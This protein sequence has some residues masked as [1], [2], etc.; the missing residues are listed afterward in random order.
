M[1]RYVALVTLAA[2]VA[3]IVFGPSTTIGANAAGERPQVAAALS[4]ISPAEF[5]VRAHVD[6]RL[7]ADFL[8]VQNHRPAYP[9]WQHIFIIPDGRILYGSATDGRLL[10][11]FP[12]RGDWV[13][14]ANWEDP[15]LAIALTGQ[16]LPRRLQDRRDEVERLLESTAGPVV[17]NPTRGLFLLPNAE[18]YGQ[19]LREWGRIY[20]RFGVP[21]EIGL[22]Q[23]MLESGLK[24]RIRSRARALGFC[25]WL[26]RNWRH[27][28]RLTPHVIEGYNQTTQAPYCAAYLTILATMY[29]SFIPALSE[30]HAGGANVGRT[31]INGERLGGEGAREQYL[32]GSQF[33]RNLR[34]ISVRRYR[35]LYRTYGLRSFRYAEMIFGNTS[36][37][38][39]LTGEIPQTEIFA[40]RA[41]RML[42][43]SEITRVTGLSV[44]ELKQFNP[45][46]VRKV[47]PQ[48]NL[49]L[50]FHV[51]EFGP[52]VAFWH[53]SAHL[54]YAAVLNQF[55]RLDADV[56]EWHDP[57][58]ESTLR[59]FADRFAATGS[60]EGTVMAAAIAYVISDLGTSRRARILDEFRSS[61]RI[62]R[63]FHE[64]LRE[65]RNTL[66]GSNG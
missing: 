3:L 28:K 65:L 61:N 14:G 12:T 32:L 38:R 42:P 33:A 55:V 40:M 56:N 60:E 48:A 23:A 6:A 57:A 8:A 46:L 63:L 50:P 18:R 20:E 62:L 15:S 29:G 41:P 21:A 45:A 52:D 58:F 51:D 19:F 35:D 7:G 13:A 10:A 53:R 24:G 43:L 2:M 37:V 54:E 22:A 9:F 16:R 26:P 1:T 44:D 30:H 31:V 36:N 25:Q 47:P 39:R 4:G 27:L 11:S 64:G 59:E 66:S 34:D 17:H 5:S 49:Y